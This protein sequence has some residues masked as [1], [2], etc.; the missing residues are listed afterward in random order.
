MGGLLP[1][2]GKVADKWLSFQKYEWGV[3]SF[4]AIAWLRGWGRAAGRARGGKAMLRESNP[5]WG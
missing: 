1:K 4:R 3:G 2:W 5:E